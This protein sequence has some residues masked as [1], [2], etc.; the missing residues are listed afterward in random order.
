[1]S[2]S[3]LDRLREHCQRLWL[4]Q[5]EQELTARLEQAAKRKFPTPTS[6]PTAGLRDRCENPQTPSDAHRDGTL[7]VS[8]VDLTRFGRRC[9]AWFSVRV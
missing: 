2:T 7:P 8:E 6:S 9:G 3:Q 1:M 4:Y 5:I